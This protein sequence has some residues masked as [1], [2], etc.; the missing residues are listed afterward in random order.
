MHNE[1]GAKNIANWTKDEIIGG[2]LLDGAAK[3]EQ[4]T[5]SGQSEIQ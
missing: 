1:L 4:E 5:P 2:N 3:I